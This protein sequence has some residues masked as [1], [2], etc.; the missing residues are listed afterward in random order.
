MYLFKNRY[1]QDWKN[2]KHIRGKYLKYNYSPIHQFIILT[3]NWAEGILTCSKFSFHNVQFAEEMFEHGTFLFFPRKP[4]ITRGCTVFKLSALS[5][6]TLAKLV[7]RISSS[8]AGVKLWGFSYQ[9]LSPYFSLMNW[10]NIRHVNV[11]PR[12]FPFKGFSL[13]APVYKS[14]SSTCLKINNNINTTINLNNANHI[15]L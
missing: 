8:C 2:V 9:N 4:S 15:Y 11:G 12:M 3:W 13:S 5:Q 10:S 14:I 1:C 7:L 6:I